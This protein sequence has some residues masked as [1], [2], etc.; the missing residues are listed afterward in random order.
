MNFPKTKSSLQRKKEKIY[1]LNSMVQKFLSELSRETIMCSFS[2]TSSMNQGKGQHG[3][4]C[5]EVQ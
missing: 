4:K 1:A 3:K 5:M 2:T